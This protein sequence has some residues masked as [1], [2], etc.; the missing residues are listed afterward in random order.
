MTSKKTIDK[1]KKKLDTNSR[2]EKRLK[3]SKKRINALS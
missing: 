1:K 3:N 2:N